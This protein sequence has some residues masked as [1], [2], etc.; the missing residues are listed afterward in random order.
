MAM[1]I[2][3][4]VLFASLSSAALA[5]QRVAL[6]VGNSGYRNAGELVNPRN[7]ATDMHAALQ[8]V[9]FHVISGVDLD[10]AAFDRKLREFATALAGAEV[11][12]FFYAGHGL[13][14]AGRNYLVPVDAQLSTSDALDFEM[15]QLEVVQRI[16]ER[17]TATNLIFLD[18][19]RNNPF[20]RNLARAM[21]TRSAEIGRGLAAMESGVGTLISF[22]TQPGNVALD[23]SGR[24]SPFTGALARRIVVASDDLSALLIDVRN[25]VRKETQN[26]QIP[27]EHS[28]LTARFY[29]HA[30]GDPIPAAPQANAPTQV[31]AAASAAPPRC[32]GIEARVGPDEKR[33]LRPKDVFR[34]C[35]SCPEMV[36]IPAG[37]FIMGSDA[38]ADEKPMHRVTIARPFAVGRF[39]VTFAEW[40]KCAAD[41]GCANNKSPSDQGWGRGRRPAIGV[42]WNDAREYAGWLSL[43]TKKNYRLL[44][45]AE[46]EYAARAGTDTRFAFGNVLLKDQAQFEADR[47][48]EVGSFPPNGFGLYDMHGNASEHV[49]DCYHQN[50]E[51]APSN[52]SPW[53]TSCNVEQWH[54]TRGGSFNLYGWGSSLVTSTARGKPSPDARH[55]YGFRIARILD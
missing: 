55:N 9:G 24:N 41:G 44:T 38:D 14:V 45:E 2:I 34:D 17:N 18:A 32:D 12:V 19:C 35:P 16:M 52:G 33:C 13:Q 31:A 54:V 6:V 43:R 28:A 5:D 39:E 49:E 22:S 25:D 36:V 26:K 29:F 21:G 1:R 3:A 37:R 8:K 48:A 20:T 23:G 7:D 11:G 4:L 42:S 53:M 15:V 40:D 50:Y 47:T 30:K 10:K 27:W 51:G 46:W